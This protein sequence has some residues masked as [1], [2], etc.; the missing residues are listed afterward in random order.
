MSST[1]ASRGSQPIKISMVTFAIESLAP[2]IAFLTLFPLVSPTR[3]TDASIVFSFEKVDFAYFDSGW[4]ALGS[5]ITWGFFSAVNRTWDPASLGSGQREFAGTLKSAVAFFSVFLLF[6]FIFKVEVSR[7]L[8]G[9]ALILGLGLQILTR[10]I[11]RKILFSQRIKGQ[12]LARTLLVGSPESAID[13]AER[14][15]SEQMLGYLPAAVWIPNKKLGSAERDILVSHN[16]TVLDSKTLGVSDIQRLRIGAVFILGTVHFSDEKIHQL[17]WNLRKTAVRLFV[18]PRLLSVPSSRLAPATMYGQVLLQVTN[19][20]FE[21]AP[22]VAKRAF[23]LAFSSLALVLTLPLQLLVALLI[24]LI[25]RNPPLFWQERVG[26]QGRIFT[27]LKF[28]TMKGSLDGAG[29]VQVALARH[30]GNAVQFKL[31]KDPR[32]TRLGSLLRRFSLDELPQFTN[33]LLGQM[34]VVGPRPH[35]MS[36]V[37]R[38]GLTDERR[39]AVKPGMTGLWQIN[40]RSDLSWEESVAFDMDYVE[41]WSLANDIVI[42][43]RTFRAVLAGRGAY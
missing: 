21:G 14:I 12:F 41:S 7:P 27:M 5:T 25:D 42:I 23:D 2:G 11:S 28:R 26:L 30:A 16:L 1:T 43:L 22:V 40:G 33:V 39:L 37:E 6:I 10:W 36:E 31:R 9:G 29:G 32:V 8:F 13:F 4:L 20:R 35:V 15:S 34:S 38:Y 19:L 18:E 3:R 24:L 17:S